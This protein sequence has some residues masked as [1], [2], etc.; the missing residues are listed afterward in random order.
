[1]IANASCHQ[2]I[3]RLDSSKL[4]S[5]PDETN[6]LVCRNECFSLVLSL[7]LTLSTGLLDKSDHAM[8]LHDAVVRNSSSS[9]H[10]ANAND[11]PVNTSDSCSQH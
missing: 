10:N 5:G 9:E 2:F 8:C 7:T 4:Q 11:K 1:M 6:C 3:S